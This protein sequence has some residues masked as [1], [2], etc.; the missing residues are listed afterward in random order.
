MSAMP[1]SM[2]GMMGGAGSA[3]RGPEM[4]G[5]KRAEQTSV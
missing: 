3:P 2:R 1:S 5:G 4:M